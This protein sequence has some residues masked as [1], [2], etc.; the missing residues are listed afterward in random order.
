[1]HHLF[2]SAQQNALLDA[3]YFAPHEPDGW[4]YFLKKLVQLS[5]S[6][7]ARLLALS[8]EADK[9]LTS[10]QINTDEKAYQAYVEHFVNLCPWRTELPWKTPGKLY[11]TR[12]DFSCDQQSFYRS[13]FF[14]DWARPLDI[15]HGACGTVM[16]E[17]G[18]TLQLMLQRTAGQGH[19][20]RQETRALNALLPHVRRALRLEALS[21]QRQLKKIAVA[22]DHT[23][24]AVVLLDEKGKVVHLSH[25][26]RRMIDALPEVTI[27]GGRLQLLKKEKQRALHLLLRA[28][29]GQSCRAGGMIS[30]EEG[31]SILVIP[32]HPEADR[33]QLF[34]I[35]AHAALYFLDAGKAAV[36][37]DTTQI[38]QLLNLSPSE[39]HTAAL[40]VQG[41]KAKDIA[42]LRGT[43]IHTV[44][45]QLKS[46]LRKTGLSSQTQLI[47]LVF[48]LKEPLSRHVVIGDTTVR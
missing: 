10:V 21:R 9:V 36:D 43:S 38:R 8:P 15:H 45:T 29:P 13:E 12:L 11:S 16:Q 48:S 6:R 32:L 3:L 34:P 30:L 5:D 7:S 41:A 2:T 46:I 26:A 28:V 20:K 18:V 47:N 37:I 35:R 31:G 33:D 44:R 4:R 1:M 39:A 19:Y 23:Y 42:L 14:N 27:P 40:I 22:D 17:H 25:K 24:H